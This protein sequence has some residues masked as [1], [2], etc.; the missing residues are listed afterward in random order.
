MSVMEDSKMS[1]SCPACGFNYDTSSLEG[2]CPLC[3][4]EWVVWELRLSPLPLE[5]NHQRI[6]SWL[7]QLPN[8]SLFELLAEA[9]DGLRVRMIVPPQKADGAINAWA[10]MT[11][12]QTRWEKV[13]RLPFSGDPREYLVLETN[14]RVPNLAISEENSDPLLAIGGQLLAAAQRGKGNSR[15]RIWLLGKDTELQERLRALSSFSYGTETGVGNSAPNPWGLRLGVLR[16]VLGVGILI[17]GLGGGLAGLKSNWGVVF[18]LIISGIILVLVAALGMLDWMKWRS[19]P[20]DILEA[21]VNNTLLNM[22]FTLSGE[23]PDALSLLSGES[24]WQAKEIP[25]W[26][27]IKGNSLTLPVSELAV[28]IAPPEASEGSGIFARDTIQDVPAPPPSK[29][30]QNAPMPIGISIANRLPIGIDPDGHG[31]ATGGTRSGK[32]SFAAAIL[33]ELLQ[34]GDDAPGIFL[35]DPHLSLSDSFLQ[36]VHELPEP[37]R[38]KAI[39]R[40]RVITPDQP[41]TIPLNLLSLPDFSW[42]GNAI[43]QLGKRIWEDYWGPRMQAALLG[44]FRLAHAWNMNNPDKQMGLM[45]V[46]FAAFNVEWRHMAM[47]YLPPAD[48]IGSLALDALLGQTNEGGGSKWNRSWSTEVISPVLSKV[49]SLELSPWLFASMHQSGFIDIEKWIKERAWVVMRLP[50]GQMGGESARLTASM[51]YNVFDAAYR[52]ETTYRPIPYYFFIDEA[53]EIGGGMKLESMLSEGAKFGARMFVLVQSLSM[54]RRAEGFEAVVQA[55]L[56]NTST[57]AYF[58]PDP[59]DADTIRAALNSTVR[60]GNM[61]LDLPTLQCWLRARIGKKWQP[62]TLLEVTPP[63]RPDP[64]T[65]QALIR[66]VI[67]AHPKDYVSSA[68]WEE[69][70]VSALKAMVPPSQHALLDEL[71]TPEVALK[72]YGDFQSEGTGKKVTGKGKKPITPT[73]PPVDKKR[74]GF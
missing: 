29:T 6:A 55:L 65:V 58:S 15:L 56:A 7:S 5:R 62:P 35:V 69:T 21:R 30:L 2:S 31:L 3:A 34:K 47:S 37:Q 40:L 41:E 24:N 64:H 42:A 54:M 70:T 51:V 57:Q 60:Y 45:H 43:V 48:R 23:I 67:A 10:S 68:L 38:K 13:E 19:I 66:E 53:Q 72:K 50:A 71:F 27:S 59:E 22:A 36:A 63:N 4:G 20:K 12:Q 74:L 26:P 25:E 52:R 49:M 46:V 1:L 17:G 16:G 33:R 18:I 61:T 11:Q 8:P 39:Q 73:H 14:S 9:D 28:L 44:L 32:T